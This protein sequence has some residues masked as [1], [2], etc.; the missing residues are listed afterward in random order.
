MRL[1]GDKII[2]D[3]PISPEDALHMVN[4][5]SYSADI[6]YSPQ[7]QAPITNVQRGSMLSSGYP[8][9]DIYP[10][11]MQSPYSAGFSSPAVSRNSYRRARGSSSFPVPDS[12]SQMTPNW[13]QMQRNRFPQVPENIN[14]GAL[15]CITQ[16]NRLYLDSLP[17]FLSDEA[18]YTVS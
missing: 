14:Q 7:G 8:N 2:Y 3:L 13:S 10:S 18:D 9:R 4:S 15:S 12:P 6:P 17:Y 11:S 16:L 5:P 1:R